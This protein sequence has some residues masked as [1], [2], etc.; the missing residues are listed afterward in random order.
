[1][2]LTNWVYNN[3]DKDYAIS[4]PSAVDVLRVRRGDCNEHTAL[5]T[6]LARAAG[7]PTKINLGI[8]YS[9]G[10]F[11]YHAWPAVYL[12]NCW[13]PIDPTLGQHV[14]D[15]THIMLLQGGYD[16]QASLMRVVGK[17]KV[18]IIDYITSIEMASIR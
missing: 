18:K 9:E 11:Y 12:D 3:I 13:L 8:V 10:M 17:L 2:A 14:A 1:V 6:A 16:S 5:F 7:I 4:L 15:A